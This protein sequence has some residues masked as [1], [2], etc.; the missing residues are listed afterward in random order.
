MILH[1]K[2]QDTG[3]SVDDIE[4]TLTE[5]AFDGKLIKGTNA[6]RIVPLKRKSGGK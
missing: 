2:T 4:V 6:V 5:E 3:L 1:F